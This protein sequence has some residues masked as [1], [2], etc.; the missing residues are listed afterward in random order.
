MKWDRYLNSLD[1]SK[2][3]LDFGHVQVEWVSATVDLPG[4]T[5]HENYVE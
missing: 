5:I 1:S 3:L 4:K 2:L